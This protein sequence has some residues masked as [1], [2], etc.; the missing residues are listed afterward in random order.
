MVN[1]RDHGE[2]GS[3][4]GVTAARR[5]DRSN[6]LF[7][8]PPTINPFSPPSPS[9][10]SQD[11]P[12]KKKTMFARSLLLAVLLPLLVLAQDGSLDGP[13]SSADAAG[14]SCDVSKCQ[15]PNCNCASVKPPGGLDPVSVLCSR[16]RRAM[17]LCG[18][19]GCYLY[20]Y[21]L[22][23]RLFRFHRQTSLNSSYSQPTMQFSRI[24]WIP[25]TSFSHS[26]KTP[27]GADPP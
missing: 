14:Y 6:R 24:P 5:R 3:Q 26:A 11:C 20:P 21:T 7:S 12:K 15:L 1:Q 2:D 22:R 19:D 18:C 10:R 13:A 23:L 25:S 4:D 16:C 17:S 27:M 8:P 9:E